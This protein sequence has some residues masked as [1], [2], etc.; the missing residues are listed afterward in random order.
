MNRCVLAAFAASACLV[1]TAPAAAQVPR[2]FNQNVLRGELTITQPPEALLNG[3]PAR[4]APGTRIRNEMNMI[5]LS[6]S[7]V[8]RPVVV[9]YTLDGAGQLRDVWIL[10][11]G[12]LARK[13][14][15]KS[16]QES[17]SWVFDPV[18]QSWSKP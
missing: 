13:P 3:K 15:P 9:H 12:E 4:L 10:N 8:G 11:E 6:G 1:A 2:L 5:S 17:R 7:L 16:E 18:Y 14:W